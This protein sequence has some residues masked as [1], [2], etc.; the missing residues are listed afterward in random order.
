MVDIQNL[1][2]QTEGSFIAT[3]KSVFNQ[4]LEDMQSYS[5]LETLF[6]LKTLEAKPNSDKQTDFY[7]IGQPIVIT[8]EGFEH[9]AKKYSKLEFVKLI[10][11]M[12]F[13]DNTFQE[14]VKRIVF[15]WKDHSF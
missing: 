15:L 4:E 14:V 7:L 12:K 1:Q 8:D 9:G 6:I 11:E 5:I 13:T 3:K 2:T 10:H